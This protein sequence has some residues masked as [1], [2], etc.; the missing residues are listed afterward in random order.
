M[1]I[2]LSIISALGVLF[3]VAGA[4]IAGW[5]VATDKNRSELF[6]QRLAAYRKLSGQISKVYTLGV[7]LDTVE[8]PKADLVYQKE[9]AA[10]LNLILAE[11]LL[12]DEH[13]TKQVFKF[14]QMKPEQYSK[15]KK[16][17]NEIISAFRDDL[18]LR[19]LDIMNQLS[20]L[21]VDTKRLLRKAQ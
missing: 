4:F 8:V 11:A 10:L 9:A 15:N 5:Y 2:F 20:S 18:T 12:L 1:Q 16:E 7:S 14:L 19:K 21:S 17:I 3:S 6:K 13:S